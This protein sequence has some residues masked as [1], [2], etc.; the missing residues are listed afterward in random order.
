MLGK[1]VS[2]FVT[3]PQ[4]QHG[5]IWLLAA[6]PIQTR[7][8]KLGPKRG[9]RH[10]IQ[11]H[12]PH[13]RGRLSQELLQPG[14]TWGRVVGPPLSKLDPAATQAPQCSQCNPSGNLLSLSTPV[15][16]D[17]DYTEPAL[18]KMDEFPEKLQTAFDPPLFGIFSNKM[19]RGVPKA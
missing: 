19:S 11:A 9:R 4:L 12:N 13:S 18:S 10:N 1:I 3:V 16:Q 14:S 6:G 17:V 15:N 7:S 5:K 2:Q 8:Q